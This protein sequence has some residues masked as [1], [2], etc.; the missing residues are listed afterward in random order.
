[1][2]RTF[3]IGDIHG[4]YKALIQLLNTINFNYENDKLIVLG[5]VTDGWPETAEVIEELLKIKRLI[6]IKGNH[7]E[8]TERFLL[9]A[10]ENGVN[11]NNNIW[12]S[13]GG[14]ATYYSYKANPELVEKHLDFLSKA[15]LYYL[16]DDNRI[17]LHAG[18]NPKLALDKQRFLDV[19]Q[20]NKSEN[21]MFYWDRSFWEK[22]IESGESDD[23]IVWGQYKEIFIGHTPTT[24]YN[25]DG[26][27]INIGNVWNMDTGATY[28]GKLSIINIDTKEVTQSE[29]VYTLYP[30]HMGRNGKY[31]VNK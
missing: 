9:D 3:C 27:P 1:M 15:L 8:W 23:A 30:E 11:R 13:Q 24:R 5:D 18:F 2:N 21:A 20:T 17:F 29:P 14:D 26:R 10:L 19:G 4:G 22:V 16:D 28:D 12:Y 25:V 31:L 7:D 6:Y